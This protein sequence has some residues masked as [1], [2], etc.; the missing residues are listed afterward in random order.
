MKNKICSIVGARPQFIK[1]ASLSRVLRREY[2]EVLIHTGQH[3]DD[4]MS[5]V[6]FD[7]LN[8][9]N[10]EYNLGISGGTHG[11]MTAAMLCALEEVFVK[12]KPNM[13]LVYGDT[14]S[15]LAAAL[16]AVKLYIPICHVE[17]GVRMGTLRNPEEI[18]RVLT[19]RV[20]R[21]LMCCTKEDVENLREEGITQGVYNTGDLMYDA[22]LYY[23][24]RLC[25]PKLGKL[26]SFDGEDI[27]LPSDYYL[28]TCHR[29]ENAGTDEPL[30]EAFSAM[31]SLDRPTIYP[32]H[33]RNCERALRLQ[34]K[35]NFGN[36]ILIKPVGYLTNLYL[37]KNAVKIVTD[38]GGVQREAWFYSKPCVTLM[39]RMVWPQTH[40][41]NMNQ[42]C[43]ANKEDILSAIKANPDF[44]CKGYPFGDGNAGENIVRHIQ[45]VL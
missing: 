1:A 39:E 42:I 38:S 22:A 25:T 12:E 7:E 34:K 28:M 43:K 21:L 29:E 14:N 20:S 10:P 11:K 27:M 23:E 33:P 36:I 41:G 26:I 30:Y 6:F 24:E 15:T 37:I 19:D 5:G 44:S 35:H 31:Q 13:V 8:I 32:V 9:P 40:I 3:Y 4:N 2:E 45:S 17:A 16:A 18:N